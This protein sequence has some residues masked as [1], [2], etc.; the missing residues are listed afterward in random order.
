[1]NTDG[2]SPKPTDGDESDCIP[3]LVVEAVDTDLSPAPVFPRAVPLVRVPE[4][5]EAISLAEL[6]EEQASD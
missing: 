5:F 6:L 4:P 1:M 3:C 2:L